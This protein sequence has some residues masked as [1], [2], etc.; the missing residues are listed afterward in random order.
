MYMSAHTMERKTIKRY[1]EPDVGYFSVP[2]QIAIIKVQ[3]NL[4]F[5]LK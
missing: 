4:T 2:V 3:I 5:A 1:L